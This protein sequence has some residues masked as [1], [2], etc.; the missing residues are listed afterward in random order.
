VQGVQR[1]V[2]SRDIPI[3]LA[4]DQPPMTLIARPMS[5]GQD[6][7]TLIGASVNVPPDTVPV[8]LSEPAA[9]LLSRGAGDAVSLP[10]GNGQRFVVAGVWRDYARQQGAIV[11]SSHDYDRLTGD[12]R[13]DSAMIML[14][15]GATSTAVSKA[16]IAAAPPGIR[17]QVQTAEPAV[18]REFALT[19]FDRSFAIT[20]LLEAVAIAVGLAGVAATATAQGI[21]RTREF[22]MLRH[23]GLSRRQIIA[24]LGCEGALLGLVGS[25]SGMAL[26]AAISQVLIHVINPQSFNWT[27]TTQFPLGLMAGVIGALV[28]ASTLTAMLAGRRAVS[29][30]A[31]RAVRADW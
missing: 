21:A 18:L 25:L 19:L 28:L 29:V 12:T 13:R 7:L 8:W 4:A 24:M 30:D 11:I 31:V 1:I 27:M 5:A 9:R 15:P 23:I 14:A 22:G 20:Y 6:A 10:L 3:T 16:L 26:G 2:F 17:Q